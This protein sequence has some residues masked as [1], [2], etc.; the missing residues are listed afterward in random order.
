MA[1]SNSTLSGSEFPPS[2]R[3]LPIWHSQFATKAVQTRFSPDGR[4]ALVTPH[5]VL[6]GPVEGEVIVLK[7]ATG[8]IVQRLPGPATTAFGMDEA[9]R[10]LALGRQ[11]QIGILEVS[12]GRTLADLTPPKTLDHIGAVAFLPDGQRLA[13]LA[14]SRASTFL[15]GGFYT[16]LAGLVWELSS[17]AVVARIPPGR[18]YAQDYPETLAEEE[19][20]YLADGVLSADGRTMAATVFA[21][22]KVYWTVSADRARRAAVAWDLTGPVPREILRLADADALAV[23]D[24]SEVI[25]LRSGD[26]VLAWALD[27]RQISGAACPRLSRNLNAVEWRAYFGDRPYKATCP[28][29]ATEQ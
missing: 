17:G 9:G 25:L 20:A 29:V 27:S 14:G 26:A 5:P 3:T 22:R 13:T 7:S 24:D 2:P 11:G 12:D 4:L 10:R 16:E 15:G 1:T 18:D 6:A 28:G 21:S 19:K 8:E 23:S